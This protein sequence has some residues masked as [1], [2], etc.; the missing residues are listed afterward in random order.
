MSNVCLKNLAE[1]TG[2]TYH[3]EAEAVCGSYQGHMICITQSAANVP[4]SICASV[5]EG[6][7]T[8]SMAFENFAP[9][10]KTQYKDVQSLTRT[11]NKITIILGNSFAWRT[12]LQNARQVLDSFAAFLAENF[13]ID[14]CEGCGS[15][16]GLAAYALN[17]GSAMYCDTCYQNALTALESNKQQIKQKKGN[18]ATG[19][20]GALL[21]SLIGV[22]V[23]VLI[24]QLGYI[25]ALSGLVM[26][27][28][29]LKGYEMLGGKINKL[30]VILTCVI[31]VLMVLFAE[32]INLAIEIL[33]ELEAGFDLSLFFQAFRSIPEFIAGG[34]INMPAYIGELVM[35]YG[36]TALGAVPTIIGMFK[37]K[38]GQYRVTK[39]A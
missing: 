34:Y 27:I 5:K 6:P 35:A 20:V 25:A 17:G 32:N 1:Q 37:Q 3:K 11:D 16:Y 30:G 2:L 23:F 13:Y 10:F 9:A 4:L 33:S 26:A 31:M 38:S 29:A 18:L 36:L 39:L 28:C 22:I 8:P 21:G 24:N 19:L 15:E 7:N 12:T 14:C